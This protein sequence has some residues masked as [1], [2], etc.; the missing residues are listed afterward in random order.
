[1]RNKWTPHIIAVTAFVVFIVLGLAC[2]TMSPEEQVAYQAQQKE[3]PG[4]LNFSA[5]NRDS[6]VSYFVNIVVDGRETNYFMGPIATGYHRASAE[7]GRITIRYRRRRDGE[8]DSLPYRIEVFTNEDK[9]SW[10]S[11]TFVIPK[12]ETVEVNIPF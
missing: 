12:G 2:A 10:A 9:S 6:N 4:L 11:R 5:I 3:K 8:P 1:M 7:D